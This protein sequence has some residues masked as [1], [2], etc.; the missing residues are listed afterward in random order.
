MLPLLV[1]EQSVRTIIYYITRIAADLISGAGQYCHTS[2][3]CEC[4]FVFFVFSPRIDLEMGLFCFVFYNKTQRFAFVLSPCVTCIK[5]CWRQLSGLVAG[6]KTTNR[7]SEE[8]WILYCLLLNL[9][10]LVA[11]FQCV[12][13][14]ASWRLTENVTLT[15]TSIHP[16]VRVYR[17]DQKDSFKTLEVVSSL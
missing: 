1:D 11:A 13:V 16:N 10:L 17:F 2:N 15:P 3:A 12:S 6:I 14:P 5:S 4:W 8:S 7:L 9:L